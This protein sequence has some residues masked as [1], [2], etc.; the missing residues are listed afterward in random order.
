MAKLELDPEMVAIRRSL[1]VFQFDP[2]YRQWRAYVSLAGMAKL[3]GTTRDLIYQIRDGTLPYNPSPR[4]RAR[5]KF[6][7]DMIQNKGLRWH[8]KNVNEIGRPLM[9]DGTPPTIPAE[10]YGDPELS[11]KKASV[12]NRLSAAERNRQGR[13]RRKSNARMADVELSK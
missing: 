7:I 6:M 8:R 1:K 13:G 11:T 10:L 3:V 9:P 4:Y 2:Q 5:L 12:Q